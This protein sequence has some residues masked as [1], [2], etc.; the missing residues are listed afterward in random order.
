ML[1]SLPEAHDIKYILSDEFIK[2]MNALCK[3]ARHRIKVRNV[4]KR[5]AMFFLAALITLSTWL[6]FD[7]NARAA[8]FLWI[9]EVYDNHITYRFLYQSNIDI[10]PTYNITWM[11][12]NFKCI[13]DDLSKVR[14]VSFYENEI[15]ND[16]VV[17]DYYLL[18]E[19]FQTQYINL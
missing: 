14:R 10:L 13:T 16:A 2:K 5:I 6:A 15:T 18:D 9:R 7:A 8:L 1:D 19:G 17:F 3:Q 12:E 4:L 11:P